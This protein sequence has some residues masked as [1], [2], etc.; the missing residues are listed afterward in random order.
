MS[1]AEG[2]NDKSVSWIPKYWWNI[3]IIEEKNELIGLHFLDTQ[4]WSVES[5][6]LS[7]A[8]VKQCKAGGTL[9]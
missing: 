7:L 5:L 9:C 3:K 2:F 1:S 6:D 4:A 8:I